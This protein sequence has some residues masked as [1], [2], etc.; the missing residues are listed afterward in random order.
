MIYLSN[1]AA[2]SNRYVECD[3]LKTLNQGHA[4]HINVPAFIRD[5]ILVQWFK[6]PQAETLLTL[7]T[8]SFRAL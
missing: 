3:P 7:T 4:W 6:F 2:E 8:F 1:L 5:T